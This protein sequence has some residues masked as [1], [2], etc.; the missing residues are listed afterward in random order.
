MTEMTQL[1]GI[2]QAGCL[3]YLSGLSVMDI[4]NRRLPVWL[5]ALGGVLAAVFQFFWKEVPMLL[6][7]AGGSVGLVFLAV[8]KVTDEDFG[9]GDSILIGIMGIYLGFWNLL[10]LLTVT[11]LLASAAA[12]AVLVKKR[13]RKK[14]LLPFVPFLGIGYAVILMLGGFSI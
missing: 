1:Y 11:F 8:S 13:F 7:V 2:S 6:V 3:L 5:L 10:A 9:Y 14:T 12:M 4:R